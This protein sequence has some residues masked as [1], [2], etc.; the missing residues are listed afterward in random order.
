MSRGH[1]QPRGGRQG[2]TVGRRCCCQ[3]N[4]RHQGAPGKDPRLPFLG[5]RHWGRVGAPCGEPAIMRAP[6]NHRDSQ[7]GAKPTTALHHQSCGKQGRGPFRLLIA[8]HPAGEGRTRSLKQWLPGG[9]S[10]GPGASEQKN[11]AEEGRVS[12]REGPRRSPT[13]GTQHLPTSWRWDPSSAIQCQQLMSARAFRHTCQRAAGPGRPPGG[14]RGS[15]L[16]LPPQRL[17]KQHL[18]ETPNWTYRKL[19]ALPRVRQGKR[20]WDCM[21]NFSAHVQATLWI[22]LHHPRERKQPNRPM[23][24]SVA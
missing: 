24:W 12:P 8:A 23:T 9:Q 7:R 20:P 22:G 1:V 5:P 19:S 18:S 16:G 17:P 10:R 6:P 14:K 11:P 4:C 3:G 15:D 13:P 21:G 2:G